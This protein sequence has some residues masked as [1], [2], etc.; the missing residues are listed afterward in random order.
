MLR[1]LAAGKG[2]SAIAESL[3]I[4][5]ATVSTHIQ[6]I[7]AKLEVHSRPEPVAYAHRIG[8]ANDVHGPDL[9][10]A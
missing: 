9:T 10:V 2:Q 8:L 3:V 7:L 6:R 1:L 4:A 5:T